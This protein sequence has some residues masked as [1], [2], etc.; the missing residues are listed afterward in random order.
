MKLPKIGA[1]CRMAAMAMP[2]TLL[3]AEFSVPESGIF[4]V[5]DAN[6]LAENRLDITK[7]AT[8]K[9][10]GTATDGVF[11]L[12][13]NLNF[14]QDEV[15]SV[16]PAVLTVDVA[17]CTTV[18]MTG[19]IR[20]YNGGGKIVFPQGV[21]LFEVGTDKCN[22]D[23]HT[24][25][26]AFQ[27]DV[28]FSEVDGCVKFVNDVS[29]ANLPTCA[30][31]IADGSRI[32]TLGKEALGKGDFEVS[33]YDVEVCSP[34]SFSKNA[35]ITVPDGKKL[36]VRPVRFS[37]S[38]SGTWGGSPGVFD[39]NVVLGGADAHIDFLNKNEITGFTG[40]ISG[41]GSIN[42]KGD[43]GSVKF[44]GKLSYAG[45]LV[46]E[47]CINSY[48]HTFALE[49]GSVVVPA[50]VVKVA[51]I[52]FR[53]DPEAAQG[54]GKSLTIN[55]FATQTGV[56]D[57]YVAEDTALTF[58]KLT[59]NMRL[60]AEGENV[61][62]T[63][64]SLSA[65][66]VLYV[67]SGVAVTVKE[68]GPNAKVVFESDAEGVMDW[69]FSGPSSGNA[70]EIQVGF[71]EGSASSAELT[72]GGKVAI[73]ADSDVKVS[74]LTVLSGAE[75]TANVLD[76]ASID[77]KGGV[78][79]QRS[80]K[81]KVA[82]WVD[83]SAGDSFRYAR[84]IYKDKTKIQ[85][86]QM[87]EWLDCR[88]DH[89]NYGDLRIAVSP[90]CSGGKAPTDA[91]HWISFP[92]VDT[93]D[94]L[95]CVW[96]A[97]KSGRAFVAKGSTSGDMTKVNIKFALLV[98]NGKNGGGNAL[99]GT[100]NNRLKRVAS[101]VSSPTAEML[102]NP[103]VLEDT[104]NGSTL[105]FRTNGVDIASP[106]QTPLTGG[107][108]IIALAKEDGV[109]VANICY[110]GDS[111]SGDKNGGQI[112]AEIMLF[113]DM[114]TDNERDLAE[115]YL[116]KKWGLKLGCE[117]KPNVG[118]AD[119]FGKG[120][121]TLA[122]DT[123]VLGGMF[124]GTVDLNGN[125]LELD[126]PADKLAFNESTVPAAD[127]VLWIDPSLEGA[128]VLS[129]DPEKPSEVKFI[130]SRDNAG[131]L[132]G[133]KNRCVASPY[134]DKT[135]GEK[136]RVRLVKE[137]KE[138]GLVDAW[139]DFRDGEENDGYRNHLQV[140]EY[141]S[142]PIPENFGNTGEGY[143]RPVPVKAGFIALDSSRSGGSVICSTVASASG[144]GHRTGNPSISTPIW[145]DSCSDQVKKADTY[146]D[147]EKIEAT[148]NGYNGRPEVMSFN[149]KEEHK[150]EDAK[151]FGYS[152]SGTATSV[153]DEI[154]GEWILYSMTQ[155]EDV[156]KGIEAYLMWKWLGKRL[157]GYSSFY[158]MKVAGDG[159]LAAAGPEYLPNELD[160]F[161]GLLEFTRTEWSF[162]I[163]PE[164]GTEAVDAVK[165]PGRDL[166][167][168]DEISVTV[169]VNG[170]VNGDYTLF[171]ADSITGAE[172]I[173]L[174]ASSKIG[175]KTVSFV[176][177]EG[178]IAVRV[179]SRGTVFVIR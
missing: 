66:S 157:D 54:N 63:I 9:L 37:N 178:E 32:A 49:S 46:V 22:G 45:N 73:S 74:K 138:S 149:M 125:R 127:R 58:G 47:K 151:V 2:M 44:R 14:V 105:H 97:P 68:A 61:S 67:S 29:L 143:F 168:P 128:V 31:S 17:D 179:A 72:L 126:I 145:R 79:N 42:L 3:A 167:L 140:K 26:T 1:I 152:G 59:G 27:G 33:S 82:L 51:G 147:G 155:T 16:K 95:K 175:G 150:P 10:S 116:S 94:G 100:E 118:I 76:G 62:V 78:I 4:E 60:S 34:E 15:T 99:L 35:T 75:I 164:G 98:F 131:I 83:A 166:T 93:I 129:G 12:Q 25:F 56:S 64:D 50:V 119:V 156:R 162:A 81:D 123:V 28:S 171:K 8:L 121:L 55:S 30:Y 124:N 161:T 169:D 107:W 101:P 43:G 80:W 86:N 115:T 172:K 153:N 7:S 154:M 39:N 120:T 106:T 70:V 114:P 41:A 71:P 6:N 89:R 113:G 163:P 144:F 170:A 87:I 104:W 85:E 36:L 20:N 158:N 91:A 160:E 90:F 177:S 21:K 141:L 65:G 139:L 159:V 134:S 136:R 176:V 96:L 174:G 88:A 137:T 48:K 18:R 53:V 92:Y 52:K 165:Y 24:N 38:Y 57:V 111:N 110:H 133:D 19:H 130:H 132:T 146:L 122:G 142:T 108:Q 173:A 5:T 23:A 69:A 40:T 135:D 103:L 84:E 109:N 11:L 13:L 148:V 77:N 112:F 117:E 102:V